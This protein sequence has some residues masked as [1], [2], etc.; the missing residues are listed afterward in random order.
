M[1]PNR[2]IKKLIFF[3]KSSKYYSRLDSNPKIRK[4]KKSV[5]SNTKFFLKKIKITSHAKMK[6]DAI[7][8]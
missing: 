7:S 3:H 5:N 8:L 2:G 4:N 1:E 6:N